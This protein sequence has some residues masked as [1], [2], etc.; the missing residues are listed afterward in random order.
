M[1]F[2]DNQGA[3]LVGRNGG[4]VRAK[5]VDVQLHFIKNEIEKKIVAL[6]YCQSRDML[7][8]GLTKPLPASVF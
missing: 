5:H 1:V 4:S 3:I 8:D 7:T 2:E 6:E